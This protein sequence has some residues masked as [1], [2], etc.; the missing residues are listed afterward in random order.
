MLQYANII[1]WVTNVKNGV[2]GYSIIDTAN[3]EQQFEAVDPQI[4]EILRAAQHVIGRFS[5]ESQDHMS[6]RLDPAASE[7]IDS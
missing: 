6:N 7:R 2:P 5:G 4:R 3:V 1:K